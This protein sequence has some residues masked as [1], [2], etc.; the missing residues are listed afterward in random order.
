MKG[1]CQYVVSVHHLSSR[2]CRLYNWSSALQLSTVDRNIQENKVDN[3]RSRWQQLRVTVEF[4][5]KD[6]YICYLINPI[7]IWQA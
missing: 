4:Q 2:H 3:Q 1:Q 6:N 7:R 5:K